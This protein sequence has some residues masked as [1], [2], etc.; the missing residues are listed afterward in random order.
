MIVQGN[1]IG[2]VGAYVEQI[3]RADMIGI[4]FCNASPLVAPFGYST[5]LW[6][7]MFGWIFFK[8]IPVP[9][10]FAGAAIV[11]GAGLYVFFRERQLGLRRPHEVEGQGGAG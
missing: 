1:H 9:L 8:E 7:F 11:A 3:A 5:M 6:A 10:V 2:R 4:A